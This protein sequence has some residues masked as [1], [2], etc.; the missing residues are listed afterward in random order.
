MMWDARTHFGGR[1]NF[2]AERGVAEE[3]TLTKWPGL[4][5]HGPSGPL[6]TGLLRTR[7]A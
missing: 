1:P 3:K 6:N 4:R 5:G 7:V 2:F